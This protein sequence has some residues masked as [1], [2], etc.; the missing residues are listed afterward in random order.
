MQSPERTTDQIAEANGDG[1]QPISP[2]R[3]NAQTRSRAQGVNKGMYVVAGLLRL[4]PTVFFAWGAILCI[5]HG[6]YIGLLLLL[7]A[8]YYGW[9]ALRLFMQ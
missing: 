8:A 1:Q 3:S 9:Q 7:A 2:V 6:V 5:T 4:V